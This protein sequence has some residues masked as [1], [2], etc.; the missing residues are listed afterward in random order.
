[1][2]ALEIDVVTGGAGFIGSHLVRALLAEGRRVRVVDD[3]SSGRRENV[4][5]GVELLEGD[6]E[7]LAERA[8]RGAAVIYHLAALV[9]VPRSVE[10]PLESHRSTAAA[11]VAILQAAERAGA[12]R[13]VLASS[14]AVYGDDPELP[15]REDQAA[16]PASPYAVAKLC[17]E[18]YARHWAAYRALETVS[19][20][21]FNVYGPRQ[22]PSSPYAAAIPI[23]LS[24]LRTGRPVPIHGDGRQTRD[25]T[26]VGDV[27]SGLLAAGRAP[28]VSGK[29]YNLASGR[30][31]SVLDLVGLLARLTGTRPELRFLPPRPGDL[32]E[33]W[34]DIGRARQDL[35]YAP[36]TSLEEGLGATL[37]WF[38]RDVAARPS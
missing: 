9:S 13:V 30:A 1:M 6:A 7:A 37:E 2:A 29:V 35:G 33:S 32:R 26:Y 18:L 22:D 10:A 31:T 3:F 17:A 14:S 21:F 5:G 28:G 16:R 4:P 38:D 11:A 25:F 15:K 8:A 24:R 27:V 19:L 23:F 34:A 20:R 36:R 12:R